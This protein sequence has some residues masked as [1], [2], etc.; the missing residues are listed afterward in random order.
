MIISKDFFDLSSFS[1]DLFHFRI[2]FTIF[3]TL[4]S[5]DLK[6]PERGPHKCKKNISEELIESLK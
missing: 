1:K 4:Q 6:R 5:R 3:M 2:P